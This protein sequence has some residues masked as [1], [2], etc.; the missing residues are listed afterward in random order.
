MLPDHSSL[1]SR[2]IK[3]LFLALAVLVVLA[4]ASPGGWFQKCFYRIGQCRP[5]C[6]ENE[7]QKGK[8]IGGKRCC[9]PMV[10]SKSSSLPEKEEMTCKT[11]TNETSQRILTDLIMSQ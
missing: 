7:K 5:N 1:L 3:L 4:Q 11:R 10:K 6:H 8:C 9:L 2:Y